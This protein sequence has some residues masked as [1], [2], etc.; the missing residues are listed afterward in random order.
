MA[1]LPFSRQKGTD[2]PAC[3]YPNPAFM[4]LDHGFDIVITNGSCIGRIVPEPDIFRTIEP[5]EPVAGADPDE[6]CIIPEHCSYGAGGQAF[7][8]S[9]LVKN[10]LALNLIQPGKNR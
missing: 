4:I 3:P 5:A 2:P 7:I 1:E 6:A 9:E 10:I 8:G